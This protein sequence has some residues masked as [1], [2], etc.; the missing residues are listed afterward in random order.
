V[1]YVGRSDAGFTAIQRR[2]GWSYVHRQTHEV[3]RAPPGTAAITGREFGKYSLVEFGGHPVWLLT[4]DLR[5]LLWRLN[6][7]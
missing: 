5:S 3:W 7:S 4:D 1:L 2:P 6:P